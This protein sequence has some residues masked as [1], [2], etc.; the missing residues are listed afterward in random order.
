M[1]KIV[2]LTNSKYYSGQYSA[3]PGIVISGGV[4]AATSTLLQDVPQIISSGPVVRG[5]DGSGGYFYVTQN[6]ATMGVSGNY[7]VSAGDSSVN[8]RN[9]DNA[10]VSLSGQQAM[11]YAN[12]RLSISCAATATTILAGGQ[13]G[14]YMLISRGDAVYIKHGSDSTRQVAVHEGMSA[15]SNSAGIVQPDNSTVVGSG[16]TLSINPPET[17]WTSGNAGSEVVYSSL[18]GGTVQRAY[19]NGLLMQSGIEYDV[20]SG[21]VVS[22]SDPLSEGDKVAF[23]YYPAAPTRN[24]VP[25]GGKALRSAEPME[26][27]LDEQGENTG[28]ER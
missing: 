2:P 9:A 3:G 28:E 25:D 7:R 21:G 5:G 13:T 23:E 19:R 16:G 17:L 4:I 15:T 26:D 11:I 24:I 20:Q 14:A 22:Y 6:G 12:S 27:I 10:M 18:D 1:I 8:I